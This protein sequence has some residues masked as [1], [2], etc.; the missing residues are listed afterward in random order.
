MVTGGKMGRTHAPS[1]H[2]PLDAGRLFVCYPAIKLLGLAIAC[3]PSGTISQP[4]GNAEH[5]FE[6]RAAERLAVETDARLVAT[7][8]IFLR[9]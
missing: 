3:R 6:H 7:L 4:A 9:R 8:P 5:S 1:S 2:C